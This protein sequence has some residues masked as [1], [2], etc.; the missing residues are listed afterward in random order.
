MIDSLKVC[1]LVL[2]N[3]EKLADVADSGYPDLPGVTRI[4]QELPGF[5]RSYQIHLTGLQVPLGVQEHL[6]MNYLEDLEV[7]TIYLIIVY[8]TLYQ[9]LTNVYVFVMIGM[10][11]QGAQSW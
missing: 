10:E 4:Y 11:I 8:L 6:N 9:L 2:L 5:A 7:P 1:S 3:S